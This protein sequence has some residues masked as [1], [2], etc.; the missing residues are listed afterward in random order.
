[1]RFSWQGLTMY[2]RFFNFRVFLANIPPHN[3]D[4]SNCTILDHSNA[5]SLPIIPS[6]HPGDTE[7]YQNVADWHLFVLL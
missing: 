2:P 6:E 1:M 7:Y 5:M 3:Q 4:L